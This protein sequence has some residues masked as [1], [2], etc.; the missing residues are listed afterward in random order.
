MKTQT[1][2]NILDKNG[3]QHI[4]KQD[5]KQLVSAQLIISLPGG[6]YYCTLEI[7]RKKTGLVYLAFNYPVRV[8][9]RYYHN[10][11]GLLSLLNFQLRQGCWEMDALA[12]SLHFRMS[13]LADFSTNTAED[14]LIDT[15][16]TGAEFINITDPCILDC[17]T[18]GKA[19]EEAFLQLNKQPD[20]DKR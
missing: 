5:T 16:M 7:E 13:Y 6:N 1:L 14:I 19:P 18:N 4:I 17:I 11:T 10:L 2:C 3:I 8:P 15:I 12:H 9:K 20:I